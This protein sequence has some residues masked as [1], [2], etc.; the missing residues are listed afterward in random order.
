M[1]ARAGSGVD[2]VAA[3]CGSFVADLGWGK[4]ADGGGGE[5]GAEGFDFGAIEVAAEVFARGAGFKVGP[6]ETFDG[7]GDVRGGGAVAD[8]PGG[9]GVAADG[10]AYAEEEGVHEG[11]VLLD[12]FAFEADVGDPV[13]AAGV[14]A[15]GDVELDLLIEGGKAL[16][17]FF[18]EPFGE[19]FGFGDGELAELGAGA[20]DGAAPKGVTSTW[21]SI[22][23]SSAMR[24]RTRWLGTL[25][26]RMFWVMAVRRWPSPNC[27]ERSARTRSWS[28]ERR[29][30]STEAPTAERPGW[31]WGV[32]PM[33]SR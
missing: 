9:S 5:V 27:S 1:P 10:A 33:W 28:P 16:L 4:L 30:R 29:P 11:S 8:G 23:R 13:L 31:R 22:F 32:I 18:D 20:G 25:A 7:F 26:M 21:R 3:A 12:L 14:G 2:G 17:H 24:S 19:G 15:A 6:E